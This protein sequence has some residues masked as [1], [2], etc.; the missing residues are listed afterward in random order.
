MDADDVW[1]LFD[2]EISLLQK[3]VCFW[4]SKVQSIICVS[5][6]LHSR[7]FD[8]KEFEEQSRFKQLSTA[9]GVRLESRK[10]GESK[11]DE[12]PDVAV[13]RGDNRRDVSDW[14]SHSNAT[15]AAVTAREKEFKRLNAAWKE[16]GKVPAD[17]PER[18]KEVLSRMEIDNGRHAFAWIP[19]YYSRLAP[20]D[21]ITTDIMHGPKNVSKTLVLDLFEGAWKNHPQC[22]QVSGIRTILHNRS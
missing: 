5:M 20:S 13:P 12:V 18:P 14:I 16:G 1:N 11:D 10:K 19:L 7:L 22:V 6:G 3:G 21:T 4:S 9:K 15:I 17:K 2:H 8:L